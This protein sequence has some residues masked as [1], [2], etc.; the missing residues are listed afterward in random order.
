MSVFKQ[1]KNYQRKGNK[2]QT[3]FII[4]GSSKNKFREKKDTKDEVGYRRSFDETILYGPRT[5]PK[6]R[7]RPLLEDL[8]RKG[9]IEKRNF[10]LQRMDEL[11][12][13]RPAKVM[14][15]IKRQYPSSNSQEKIIEKDECSN[16][17]YLRDFERKRTVPIP[18]NPQ[19]MTKGSDD[20]HDDSSANTFFLLGDVHRCIREYLVG[21]GWIEK[22]CGPEERSQLIRCL[23]G[24]PSGDRTLSRML[25]TDPVKFIWV[26]GFINWSLINNN[27]IVSRIP[28]SSY[29]FSKTA[30]A[31]SIRDLFPFLYQKG[32]IDVKTPRTYEVR[33]LED[34]KYFTKQYRINACISL[35]RKFVTS[36]EPTS[37]VQLFGEDGTVPLDCVDFAVQRVVEMIR[38][39]QHADIDEWHFSVVS[40]ED[41]NVFIYRFYDVVHQDA[42]FQINH[43]NINI[44]KLTYA[45]EKLSAIFEK[46]FPDT[47]H[48]GHRNLWIVKPSNGSCGRGVKVFKRLNEIQ[49]YCKPTNSY[50]IQK[51][52]E[53]PL[54]IYQTKFDVRQWFLITSVYPL[55]IWMYNECYLRFCSQQFSL[56]NVHESVHLCNN[57][58]QYKYKNGI[59]NPQ[60]PEDNMWADSTFQTYLSDRDSST[61]W[62]GIKHK[63]QE[64]IIA[65]C[66]V[67]QDKM[68]HRTNSFHLY[69]ADFM[70][71]PDYDVWLIEINTHPSMKY[72]TSVTTR[73]CKEVLQDTLKV[74]LD[75]R[76]NPHADTGKFSEIYR[77]QHHMPTVGVP[78]SAAGVHARKIRLLNA[79]NPRDPPTKAFLETSKTPSKFGKWLSYTSVASYKKHNKINFKYVVLRHTDM[80]L[81]PGDSITQR[82]IGYAG[83]LDKVNVTESAEEATEETGSISDETA[84]KD[85]MKIPAIS[86]KP[87]N[88][89]TL[90]RK[91][92]SKLKAKEKTYTEKENIEDDAENSSNKNN[93][94]AKIQNMSEIQSIITQVTD[95]KQNELLKSS[96]DAEGQRSKHAQGEVIEVRSV[97][98]IIKAKSGNTTKEVVTK[99]QEKVTNSKK[100]TTLED[101]K[102]V[103]NSETSPSEDTPVN[104]RKQNNAEN[105][106]DTEKNKSTKM[107][108]LAA[109]PKQLNSERLRSV[110]KT[111]NKDKILSVP[112][113]ASTVIKAK[114]ES[115]SKVIKDSKIFV[116]ADTIKKKTG[117]MKS[118]KTYFGAEGTKESNNS[119]KNKSGSKLNKR[120]VSSAKRKKPNISIEKVLFDKSRTESINVLR[121]SKM[122]R[123]EH[124]KK[125]LGIKYSTE[126]KKMAN[127]TRALNRTDTTSRSPNNSVKRKMGISARKES[128]A[129]NET[130]TKRNRQSVEKDSKGSP[131]KD[132]TKTHSNMPNKKSERKLVGSSKGFKEVDSDKGLSPTELKNDVLDDVILEPSLNPE[133]LIFMMSDS[134][135]SFKTALSL[136]DA[137]TMSYEDSDFSEQEKSFEGENYLVAQCPSFKFLLEEERINTNSIKRYTNRNKYCE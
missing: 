53:N 27:V 111:I 4:I 67:S 29:Y 100:V 49:Q 20:S 22:F 129:K 61:V 31:S 41:W 5:P 14:D 19:K 11:A 17:I 106:S 132:S 74:G 105:V 57:S 99:N 28:S 56:T 45:C 51:Y 1:S 108:E 25:A 77:Q 66:L 9:S 70:I 114:E 71:T 13:S 38:Y 116:L 16:N 24:L 50:V 123:E 23:Q 79:I 76:A 102:S 48:D 96:A 37:R 59:R 93:G 124:L 104:L 130:A 112:K 80:P 133:E 117:P 63:M 3:Q 92:I 103:P 120:R 6:L 32:F 7:L 126:R 26:N 87:P 52:I 34:M 43:Q 44:P 62:P 21:N 115:V 134:D 84:D 136:S 82:D 109:K 86:S 94:N 97:P 58:I 95:T 2:Y 69:G 12:G 122:E 131:P 42:K 110:K 39:H 40:E 88:Q 30:L 54:L 60:L 78:A 107:S 90:H 135:S 125:Q 55:V 118:S 137:E 8:N 128:K 98:E 65:A 64:A 91:V 127:H 101:P 89:I 121:V 119:I 73:M 35:M 18:R 81:D 83:V 72:S 68:Y 33:C 46:Y 15:Y 113:Q 10:M 75:R 47:K 85:K 36:M